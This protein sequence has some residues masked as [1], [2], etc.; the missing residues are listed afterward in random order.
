M[1]QA[2]SADIVGKARS[3]LVEQC[4]D[5]RG[6]DAVAPRDPADIKARFA[7]VCDHVGLDGAQ[8]GGTDTAYARRVRVVSRC[9]ERQNDE[10]DKVAGSRLLCGGVQISVRH[11]SSGVIAKQTRGAGASQA[12]TMQTIQTGQSWFDQ[13]KR[14]CKAEYRADFVHDGRAAP[15]AAHDVEVARPDTVRIAARVD[16]T[17]PRIRERKIEQAI[18]VGRCHEIERRCLDPGKVDAAKR[19]QADVDTDRNITREIDFPLHMGAERR[20][21]HVAP[22]RHRNVFARELQDHPP[23]SSSK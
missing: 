20:F 7:R 6:A 3:V 21:D 10:V 19:A 9:A 18:V 11:E 2:G 4:P 15:I 23:P 16:H 5:R 14:H 1:L 17:A 12:A 8:S 22:D 13:H